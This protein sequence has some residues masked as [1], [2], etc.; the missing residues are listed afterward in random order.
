MRRALLLSALVLS[1][2]AI[3]EEETSVTTEMIS[4]QLEYMDQCSTHKD[5]AGKPLSESDINQS[6]L[7]QA[8]LAAGLGREG[9]CFNSDGWTACQ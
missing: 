6:C 2:P 8:S 7:M 5:D 4:D 3:A 1:S 9:L